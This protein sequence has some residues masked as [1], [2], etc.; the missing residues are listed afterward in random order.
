[1]APVVTLGKLSTLHVEN[2]LDYAQYLEGI[3]VEEEGRQL[4][5][6]SF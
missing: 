6:A 3:K 5:C 4:M 2:T 1:M